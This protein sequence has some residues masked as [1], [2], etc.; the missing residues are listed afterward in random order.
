MTRRR[1][2]LVLVASVLA[3]AVTAFAQRGFDGGSNAPI[4][5]NTPY[6]GK[7]TFVRLRYGRRSASPGRTTTPRAS[8]T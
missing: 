6:D 3:G 8:R 5:P 7:F 4:A 2:A 1:L